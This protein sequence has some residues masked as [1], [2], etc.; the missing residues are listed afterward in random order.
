M[1]NIFSLPNQL[2]ESEIFEPLLA[3]ENILIERIVSTGQV[4][5][6][7]EWYNQ[8]KDEWVVLLQGEAKLSYADG[9][10]L[11]LQAGD[12]VFLPAHEKH[13]VDY[14]SSKPPCIWLAIHGNFQLK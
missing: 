12:Y 2:V 6:E 1:A 11:I 14:T 10:S 13:R 9:S 8:E 4:T 5:P 3:S 7:G